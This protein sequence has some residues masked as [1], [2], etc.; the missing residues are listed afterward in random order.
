MRTTTKILSAMTAAVTLAA[1][2]V[3]QTEAA[4]KKAAPVWKAELGKLAPA[5]ELE[6]IDGKSWSLAGLRGKTVVLEWFNPE[7]PAVQ[8]AHRKGSSLE[9]LGNRAHA[10]KDVVWL[11]V[12][13][14]PSGN[15][16]HELEKNQKA[17]EA[18]GVEYPIL[19]D[20]SGWVGK[21]YGAKTTPHMF[22][23]DP[24]GTLAY[25]GG[26]D[27]NKGT[28]LVEAALSEVRAGGKVS[29][30]RTKN[31]GCSV[32]Y[33]SK[34]GLGIAAPDFELADLSGNSVRLSDY[35][36]KVVVLEWFNP[37]CPFVVAAHE[38]GT[39]EGAAGH[40]AEHDV[41]WLAINSAPA[42]HATTGAKNAAAAKK[43]GME[44]PILLDENGRVGKTFG[45]TTTP[46]M[47]VLDKR[48][49][50]VYA[51]A[52]DDK[53]GASY[54]ET[55]LAEVLSGEP[56]SQPKTKNYGC[57]VKYGKGAKKKGS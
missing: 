45:A 27:D 4:A 35:R 43:W 50:L 23:I 25:A 5:F 48:G 49:V 11:A 31:Y 19:R 36:G 44:H 37:T 17:R 15:Q 16:G 33:S 28:N 55:T 42:G 10:E 56:V 8:G 9:S 13:S 32:K 26:H 1:V 18:M 3:A 22:I 52:H 57:N 30:P 6:D 39:L 24:R 34:A 41:V 53:K 40:A 21:A 12:N 29:T 38:G 54:V 20:E 2:S 47:F 7:C 46:H 51:G 14:A